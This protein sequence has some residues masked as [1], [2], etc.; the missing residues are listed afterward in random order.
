M[1]S[2]AK[3]KQA[4]LASPLAVHL[5]I[6]SRVP[7]TAPTVTEI[8]VWGFE[9]AIALERQVSGLIATGA[10]FDL[11]IFFKAAQA[12]CYQ[13]LVP[14]MPWLICPDGKVGTTVFRGDN[15]LHLVCNLAQLYSFLEDY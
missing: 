14:N 8:Q 3:L 12:Q 5:H 7:F 9:T 10:A 15:A 1:S 13:P 4:V 6:Q 2:T 11:M